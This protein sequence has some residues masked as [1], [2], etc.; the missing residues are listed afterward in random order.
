MTRE[1]K[2]GVCL[3]AAALPRVLRTPLHA[4]PGATAPQLDPAPVSRRA[5]VAAAAPRGTS[6]RDKRLTTRI[7]GQTS[8]LCDLPL[9][10]WS[11]TTRLLLP[12]LQLLA[13]LVH[14]QAAK[15]MLARRCTT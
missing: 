7:L 4:T 1:D 5:P 15:L 2:D 14:V 9:P 8:A 12:A 11:A 3:V 10:G 13:L 6:S